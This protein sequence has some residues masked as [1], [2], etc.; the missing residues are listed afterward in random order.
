MNKR[1]E[2][3]LI[4]GFGY[5]GQY[6]AAE[7]RKANADVKLLGTIRRPERR[8]AL[9]S[10]GVEPIVYDVLTGDPKSLP[11]VDVVV[12]CVGFDRTAGI[13]IRR[14]YVEGAER[15]VSNM[16]KPGKLIYISSTGVFGDPKGAWVDES[17]PTEPVD[18]SGKACLAAEH[19]L[20]EIS[21]KRRFE[22]VVLRL[23][24][25][26]GPGRLMNAESLRAGKPIAAN[27]D[28]HVNLIHV[29]DAAQVVRLA[30][31]KAIDGSLYLVSDGNPVLRRDFYQSLARELKAPLPKF[32][33]VSATRQRGDRRIANDK[34]L[35]ELQPMFQYPIFQVAISASLG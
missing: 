7:F 31:E 29:E 4:V 2:S 22:L 28:A 1:I 24:G 11:Q 5:L 18:D 3:V 14:V 25:I 26:Y 19:C 10:L 35:K 8:Q 21:K 6:V 34:L 9:E 17:T 33:P 32:D 27:P 16:P 12:Y 30:A 13:P 20:I 15:T 23:A